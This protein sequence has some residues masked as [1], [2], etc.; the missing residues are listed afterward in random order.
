MR[1]LALTFEK[2]KEIEA[3]VARARSNPMSP[4]EIL[5]LAVPGKGPGETLTLADR[6]AQREQRTTFSQRVV[7]PV[8]YL[9]C[10]SF[11]LQPEAGLC[12]HLSVSV[13]TPGHMPHMI[14]VGMI[15]EAFG[16]QK[17]AERIMWQ[18]EVE[19]GHVAINI[20]EVVEKEGAPQ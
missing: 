17:G 9:C 11:E 18:E 3:A 16:F 2:L 1:V 14:A 12:R 10:F 20:V 6:T 8:G 15:A 19:P 13:D 4:E 7:I 5:R